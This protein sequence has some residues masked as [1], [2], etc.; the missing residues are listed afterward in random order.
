MSISLDD[1]H[2]LPFAN[3]W[4]RNYNEN[5]ILIP[6]FSAN[7]TDAENQA[8]MVSFLANYW[9]ESESFLFF[10]M[11]YYE[12]YGSNACRK[13]LTP[14]I[15]TYRKKRWGHWMLKRTWN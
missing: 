11:F 9:S 12:N 2:K 10:E 6:L 8:K 1:Y 14:T 13:V 15:T 3:Y 4:R 7:L 5:S